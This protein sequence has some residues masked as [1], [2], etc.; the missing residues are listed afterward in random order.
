MRKVLV[1]LIEL[2]DID[3][4]LLKLQEARGDLPQKVNELVSEI[5]DIANN[6]DQKKQEKKEKESRKMAVDG[7]TSMLKEKLKKYQNQLYQVKTNKEYDAMTLEID[8]CEKNIDELEYEFLELEE[9]IT[10]LENV[11]SEAEETLNIQKQLL[12]K[13][14]KH[15]SE[16]ME[17]TKEKEKLLE[18]Q[19]EKM[20]KDISR[21]LLTTYDRIRLNR[22]GRALAYLSNGSCSDCSTRIPPQRGMEIRMMDTIYYCEVCGRILVWQSE[23]KDNSTK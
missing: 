19:R 11:I 15:L 2:Q 17:K 7:E 1:K 9:D 21:P 10:K 12:Q 16:M 23:D 5:D 13:K 20:I 18:E 22:G 14:E 8:N 4:Q 3:N 6:V